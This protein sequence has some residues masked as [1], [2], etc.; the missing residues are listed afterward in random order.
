MVRPF[1]VAGVA[2]AL[3]ILGCI[4]VTDDPR[5]R[6]EIVTMTVTPAGGPPQTVSEA[7]SLQFGGILTCDS[8]WYGEDGGIDACSDEENRRDGVSILAYEWVGSGLVPVWSPRTVF[9]VVPEWDGPA[10]EWI[11]QIPLGNL[12]C[13]LSREEQD[14]LVLRGTGC[15]GPEGG[16]FAVELVMDR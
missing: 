13:T 4:G 15:S 11:G 2:L 7:G 3:G 6:F 14:P 16:P 9:F 12:S 1:H 5:G 10:D 8:G